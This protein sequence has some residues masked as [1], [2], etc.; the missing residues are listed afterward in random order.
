MTLR[1][2]LCVVILLVLASVAGLGQANPMQ[3]PGIG[4]VE[5][6]PAT[7]LKPG[8]RGHVWTIFEG[9]TPEAVPAE[10]IGLWKNAAGPGQ[11]IIL[12]KLGGKAERTNVAGGMSGSPFYIDGKLVGAV[13]TRISVFSPDAICG[14]TP[15]ELMLEISEFDES[16]PPESAAALDWFTPRPAGVSPAGAPGEGS[17]LTPIETPF[18][19][20]GFHENVLRE[21][22]PLLRQVGLA[23]VQGGSSGALRGAKPAAGWESAL[24]PGQG[25]AAVLV[26]GDMTISVQGTVTYNDGRRILAFGHSA[27]DLGPVDMPM[28]RSE[29]IMTLASSYQPNKFA[30][31]TEVV[32]ALRQDRRSG[33]L[34]VAGR[35]A[36]TIP[37]SV[38]V[39][40]WAEDGAMVREKTYCYNV[41]VHQRYTPNL[42]TTT[43]YNTMSGVNDFG[44]EY[45]YRL[46]GKVELDGGRSLSLATMQAPSELTSPAP[47][48]VASWVG[49]RV[50]RLFANR[51]TQP[52]FRG[53]DLSV[54]LLPRRRVATIENAWTGA[55]EVEA[56]RQVPVRV[57]LRPYRG[58]R[59]EREFSVTIPPGLAAGE[60][61]IL[62]SD[63]DT[64]N[65]LQGG[66]SGRAN[67]FMDLDGAISLINQERANNKLYVSLL[68]AAPTVYYDDKI[69]PSIPGSVLNVMQSGRIAGRSFAATR[70]TVLEQAAIPFDFVLSGGYSLT[71]T[72]K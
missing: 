46:N 26:S 32:G 30:N 41:F 28:A 70:E 37:V 22:A 49:E 66:A 29:V 36:E 47:L 16:Q 39:R 64:L 4:P 27:M 20:S 72:V 10:V 44:E 2:S 68:C 60:Y 34:G 67:A 8:M 51:T 45:T 59:V 65:R 33:M 24:A 71:I 61:R 6:M 58:A 15:I 62:L 19:F 23:A 69:M 63:A 12:V 5:I 31:A 38:T 55:A 14:V 56:G 7:D 11:D 42:V 21:V 3:P 40:T 43:L 1:A 25:V 9:A 57:F 13:S 35:Q 52:H 54:D 50:N 48:L 18:V 17:L 53:M